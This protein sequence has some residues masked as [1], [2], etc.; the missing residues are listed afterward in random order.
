MTAKETV[1]PI[2]EAFT[3][4]VIAPPA[5]SGIYQ[6]IR[7]FKSLEKGSYAPNNHEQAFVQRDETKDLKHNVACSGRVREQ[8]WC[9]KHNQ[10]GVRKI[11]TRQN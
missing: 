4:E 8:T 9:P 5:A 7:I 11:L 1:Q 6:N 2:E 3:E 10:D